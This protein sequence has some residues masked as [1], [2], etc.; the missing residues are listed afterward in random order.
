MLFKKIVRNPHEWHNHFA[1]LPVQIITSNPDKSL[2]VATAWLTT[3]LR[4]FET[5]LSG[6][7]QW[8]YRLPQEND[9]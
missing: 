5:N 8:V 6:T 1:W 4:K 2:L 3:V 9:Q 7:R